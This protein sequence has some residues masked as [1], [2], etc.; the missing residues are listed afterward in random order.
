LFHDDRGAQTR[1]KAR[2]AATV[3]EGPIMKTSRVDE[4]VAVLKVLFADCEF[5]DEGL[6]RIAQWFVHGDLDEPHA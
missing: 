4:L 3:E 1:R 5:S 6:R 2:R